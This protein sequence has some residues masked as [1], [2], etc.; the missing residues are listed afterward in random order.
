MSGATET[1]DRP[2]DAGEDAEEAEL[3]RFPALPLPS[4]ASFEP[5]LPPAVLLLATERVLMRD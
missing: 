5:A 4:A 2:S 1:P 3:A